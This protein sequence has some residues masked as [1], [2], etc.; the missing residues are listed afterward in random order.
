MGGL[1]LLPGE[2]E[3]LR[4][5]PSP[6]GWL[7]RYAAALVPALWGCALW[8]VFHSARWL[9]RPHGL[10]PIFL[11]SPFAAHLWSLGGL[12]LG[13][14]ALST[15]RRSRAPLWTALAV[16]AT[17][18]L[19]AI[20]A[21]WP[22]EQT[23]PFLVVAGSAV[24]LLW[25]ELRRLGTS[26]HLTTLRLVVRTSF[27]RRGENAERHAELSDVDVRQ[28]PLGKLLDVGTLLPVATPPSPHPLRLIGVPRVRRVLRLVEVLVRQATATDYLRERQGLEV[29]QAEAL[30][31][32]QRR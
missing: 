1:P 2:R 22:A 11:G 9:A 15:V 23:L 12:L 25:A 3:V 28:G 7:P 26:H 16:G 29:Q 8:G 18:S 31:A 27:P 19:V 24:L 21:P 13:G 32:P 17:A 14:Q 6:L 10:G 4:F 30:A 5:H 20:P